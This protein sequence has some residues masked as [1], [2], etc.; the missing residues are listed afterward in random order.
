MP[1]ADMEIEE[2]GHRALT[3]SINHIAGGA[4]G[5]QAGTDSLKAFFGSDGPD[6]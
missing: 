5:D 4:A 6:H 1:I 3:Q 2:I